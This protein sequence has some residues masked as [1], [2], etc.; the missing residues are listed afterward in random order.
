MTS[1]DKLSL[2][3]PSKSFCSCN[4]HCSI[5]VPFYI[6]TKVFSS[7]WFP[8]H[9]VV[10][11]IWSDQG[12]VG[13]ALDVW[14]IDFN[15]SF[16]KAY[17]HISLCCCSYNVGV[18]LHVDWYCDAEIFC[19][20]FFLE[21]VQVSIWLVFFFVI[22]ITKNLSWWNSISQSASHLSKAWRSFWR[23][24]QLFSAV[25]VRYMMVLLVNSVTEECFIYS[26][27]SFM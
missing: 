1:W 14:V 20:S 10:L 19:V 24:S 3:S 16:Q 8:Y 27:M 5:A 2:I 23:F 26:A 13:V 9:T 21:G 6:N 7:L 15:V 18:P 17:V 22:L 4:F 12:F 25:R 11:E